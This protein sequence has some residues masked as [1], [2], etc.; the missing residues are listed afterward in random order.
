MN[1]TNMATQ[2][3][4]DN[5]ESGSQQEFFKNQILNL[6]EVE[7]LIQ[8]AKTILKESKLRINQHKISIP[9]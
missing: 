1:S 7:A 3:F 8:E 4:T 9:F 5:S 6:D 2:S